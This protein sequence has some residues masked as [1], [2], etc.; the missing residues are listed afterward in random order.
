MVWLFSLVLYEC[1]LIKIMW[2]FL[3]KKQDNEEVG[4]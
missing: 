3:N 1:N 4:K 2:L